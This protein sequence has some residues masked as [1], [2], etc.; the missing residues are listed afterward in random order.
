MLKNMTLTQIYVEYLNNFLSVEGFASHYDLRLDHATYLIDT[1][2]ALYT[3][4]TFSA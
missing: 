4:D 2:R 3:G 1:A